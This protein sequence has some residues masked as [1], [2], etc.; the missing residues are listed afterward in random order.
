VSVDGVL[1]VPGFLGFGAFGEPRDDAIRYFDHVIDALLEERPDLRDRVLPT[2]PPPTADVGTR[3]DHLDAVIR[4]VLAHGIGPRR[5]P[6]DRLHLV[7]H[8]AGGVD[9]RLVTN[10]AAA[11]LHGYVGA[12]PPLMRRIGCVVTIAAP[13]H[14]TPIAT[15]LGGAFEASVS[16]LSIVSI[17][18]TAR[19][20]VPLG[21]TNGAR[22]LLLAAL[23]DR[24]P[25][26]T[27]VS[28]LATLDSATAAEIA[29]YLV[30]IVGDHALLG[31]L[32]PDAMQAATA[33]IAGADWQRL[34]SI[35]TVAPPPPLPLVR[36]LTGALFRILY[37]IVYAATADDAFA[38]RAFPRGPWVHGSN[39]TLAGRAPAA[40]DGIVPSTSQTLDGDAA[41]IIE[42][43]HLDVIGHF[44]SRRFRG[45]TVFKSG[46]SFDDVAFQALWSTIGGMLR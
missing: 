17:L 13:L 19:A 40:N 46:A 20:A 15:R 44:A 27:V 1:L 4:D 29:Q 45:T 9:V 24:I 2:A 23:R 30:A 22:E 32:R 35:V 18:A 21:A 37:A 10:R 28:L 8:S 12:Q 25:N 41:A 3:C 39:A 38:P 43:D 11:A 14:G 31:D 26:P 5:T 33:G 42:A 16:G 7:G 36:D 6:I 34:R